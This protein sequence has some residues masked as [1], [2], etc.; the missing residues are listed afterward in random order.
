MNKVLHMCEIQQV[1]QILRFFC[2]YETIHRM[3]QQKYKRQKT[4][5]D[6]ICFANI[7]FMF[8]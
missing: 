4:Y 3:I 8:V 7:R 1:A 2:R 6:S 5:L